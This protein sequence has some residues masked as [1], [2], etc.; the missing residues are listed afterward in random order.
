M[1]LSLQ[2]IDSSKCR[3]STFRGS[4]K[5][6]NHLLLSINEILKF[7]CQTNW[8]KRKSRIY[9]YTQT[10]VNTTKVLFLIFT[11]L[12]LP[13]LY[14]SVGAS[15]RNPHSFCPARIP[16]NSP[17]C[18]VAPSYLHITVLPSSLSLEYL[19]QLLKSKHGKSAADHPPVINS[20]I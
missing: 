18:M 19:K 3:S 6:L 10:S 14:F 11:F 17:N 9:I 7:L 1:L 13:I 5:K 12:V 20:D 16:V 2:Q 4:L 15:P 8:M